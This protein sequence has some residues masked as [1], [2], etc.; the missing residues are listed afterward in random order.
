MWASQQGG[1]SLGGTTG[2]APAEGPGGA[3]I[4]AMGAAVGSGQHSGWHQSGASLG[5]H[6]GGRR[7]GAP[8]GGSGRRIH[9]YWQKVTMT[10]LCSHC[11]VG[12]FRQDCPGARPVVFRHGGLVYTVLVYMVFAIHVVCFEYTPKPLAGIFFGVY[13]L[14][15]CVFAMIVWYTPKLV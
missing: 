6:S 15:V 1:S 8:Q 2:G 5:H 14:C 12:A 11:G 13:G 9:P 4:G 10:N 3:A 7:L